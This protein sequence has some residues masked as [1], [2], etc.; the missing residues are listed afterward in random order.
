MWPELHG[1]RRIRWCLGPRSQ[2]P[3]TGIWG[4]WRRVPIGIPWRD[5][6]GSRGQLSSGRP[7][8][9]TTFARI[10]RELEER[11][12]ATQAVLAGAAAVDAEAAEQLAITRQQR[13][14]VSHGWPP[15]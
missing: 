7:S 10:G 11:A 2:R 14:P 1:N 4:A 13:L 3:S 8:E 9:R 15:S 12:A 5:R 6:R